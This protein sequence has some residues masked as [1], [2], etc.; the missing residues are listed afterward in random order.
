MDLPAV[1]KTHFELLRV[2]VHIDPGR[3]EF[4]VNEVRRLTPVVQHI[5]I[6]ESNGAREQTIADRTT[7]DVRIL[8]IAA[9]PSGLRLSELT[10]Q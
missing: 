10:V 1:T 3:I 8:V 4:K 7:I 9:R 2:G 5:A 6:T